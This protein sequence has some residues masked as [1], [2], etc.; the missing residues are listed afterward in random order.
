MDKSDYQA[1]RFAVECHLANNIS[2]PVLARDICNELMRKFV[3][4]MAASQHKQASIKRSFVT[5][6]RDQNSVAPAWASLKP[7]IASRLPKL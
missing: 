5:F 1:L 3:Q 7:G 4:A 6:R 2:C